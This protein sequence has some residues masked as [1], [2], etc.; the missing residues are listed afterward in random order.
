MIYFYRN[1]YIL[2]LEICAVGGGLAFATKMLLA[3]AP[4]VFVAGWI[5]WERIAPVFMSQAIV[6]RLAREYVRRLGADAVE[7]LL[8]DVDRAFR[9]GEGAEARCL[10]RV[11]GA[12][13][14]IEAE[15][16]PYRDLADG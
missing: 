16:Q 10:L 14:R 4:F 13:E 15:M 5:A 12:A 11:V 8:I 7:V 9:R 6:E 2:F 1:L 3:L